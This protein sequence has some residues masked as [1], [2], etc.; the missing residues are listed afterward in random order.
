MN[1]GECIRTFEGHTKVVTCVAVLRSD[2]RTLIATGSDDAS[3]RIWDMGT[4]KCLRTLEGHLSYVWSLAALPDGTLASGAFNVK[5]WQPGTGGWVCVCP[6]L[7]RVSFISFFFFFL[8][9]D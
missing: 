9:L 2:E 3:I 4:G 7:Y 5:L 8:S 1:T 6:L